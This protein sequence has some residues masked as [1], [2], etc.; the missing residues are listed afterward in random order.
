MTAQ[1]NDTCFHRKIEYSLSGISGTGLF[2]PQSLGLKPVAT[3]SEMAELRTRFLTREDDGS[4]N[5]RDPSRD[6]LSAWIE[7]CFSREY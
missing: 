3:S 5:R 1:I 6:E 2:E 7:K 4:V